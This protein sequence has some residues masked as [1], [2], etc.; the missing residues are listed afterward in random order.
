MS[1]SSSSSNQVLSS[2]IS[3][4]SA[5]ALAI[6]RLSDKHDPLET[7][8]AKLIE[9]GVDPDW[10][11]NIHRPE[12]L[13]TAL[14]F[15][16]TPTKS[17][18]FFSRRS[19]KSP[20]GAETRLNTLLT[21]KITQKYPSFQ[22]ID[23]EITRLE[24]SAKTR[25]DLKNLQKEIKTLINLYHQFKKEVLTQTANKRLET[26]TGPILLHQP[27]GP[28]LQLPQKLGRRLCSLGKYGQNKKQNAYGASAVMEHQGIFLKREQFNPLSPGEEFLV[29]SFSNLLSPTHGSAATLLLKI[30]NI[31]IQDPISQK[32][33]N[34][35]LRKKYIQT[36]LEK[37]TLTH[38]KI[39]KNF[40]AAEK[41]AY[42][43]NYER[44]SH[45]LQASI[46]V[47]GKNLREYIE[48]NQTL[49]NITQES[50][51]IQL[52]LTLLLRLGDARSDNF[53][54]T[55]ESNHLRLIDSDPIWQPYL[56]PHSGEHKLTVRSTTLLLPH[57]DNPADPTI[58][59]T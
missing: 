40:T 39:F 37:Q 14:F 15:S 16:Q 58:C 32:H 48:T 35:P 52:L 33:T 7:T 38:R 6:Q 2:Y 3:D 8:I 25:T 27:S 1:S 18:G 51:T 45:I 17:G 59:Q 42:P 29:K 19:K 57:M 28:T 12:A 5:L 21:K 10:L 9:R 34:N 4:R 24:K 31:W 54:V 46:G 11:Q 50:A 44:T 53:M 36:H 23:Q 30:Q 55:Q 43:F 47:P 26:I 49:T 22:T 41:K 13:F 20:E 56:L